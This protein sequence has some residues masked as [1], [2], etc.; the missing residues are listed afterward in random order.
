MGA[1][2]NGQKIYFGAQITQ[3]ASEIVQE[4]GDSAV[5]VM[6][7]KATTEAIAA[8]T[9]ETME[10]IDAATQV[11]EGSKLSVNVGSANKMRV[12]VIDKDGNIAFVPLGL[13]LSLSNG[14]LAYDPTGV[15]VV[16]RSI[17][18]IDKL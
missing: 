3:L 12:L 7:Q 10:A 17:L 4:P 11:L 13:G 9:Q 1:S 8:A 15:F 18:G 14:V 16:G 5:H 6:S 2:F